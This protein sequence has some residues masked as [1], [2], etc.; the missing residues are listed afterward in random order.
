MFA[1]EMGVFAL[2]T[3]VRALDKGACLSEGRLAFA[4]YC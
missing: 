3:D 4:R 1:L 2:T